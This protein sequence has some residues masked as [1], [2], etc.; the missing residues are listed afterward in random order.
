MRTVGD[1]FR[2]RECE[3]RVFDGGRAIALRIVGDREHVPRFDSGVIVRHTRALEL[4]EA[5]FRARFRVEDAT[6]IEQA[7]GI[8]VVDV[9]ELEATGMG[10]EQ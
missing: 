3:S 5:I 9:R 10:R 1:H 8:A 6:A 2:V 7:C 4:L